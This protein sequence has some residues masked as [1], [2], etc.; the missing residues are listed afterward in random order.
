MTE[1]Y[2]IL[3]HVCRCMSAQQRNR[4]KRSVEKGTQRE[5]LGYG[6][7]H[8]IGHKQALAKNDPNQDMKN[9]HKDTG[10]PDMKSNLAG[11]MGA[12]GKTRVQGSIA[13]VP[14]AIQHRHEER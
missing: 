14:T 4:Y 1:G 12:A 5:Q 6:N 2:I 13:R 10:Q 11:A 8:T 9:M 7:E 3:H